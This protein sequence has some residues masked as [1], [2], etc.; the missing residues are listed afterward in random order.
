MHLAVE[1]PRGGAPAP[2]GN[3]LLLKLAHGEQRHEEQ[4]ERGRDSKQQIIDEFAS[5]LRQ[6]SLHRD[7]GGVIEGVFAYR[8]ISEKTLDTVDPAFTPKQPA[9]RFGS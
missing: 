2:C 5:P 9:I 1:P 4:P 3:P 8:L 7:P 6:V